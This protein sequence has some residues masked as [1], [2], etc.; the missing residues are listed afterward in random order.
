MTKDSYVSIFVKSMRV[1]LRVGL[2]DFEKDAP[3]PVDVEVELFT[4]PAYLRGATEESIIDYAKIYED[5]KNWEFRDHVELLEPYLADL[6][7]LA[8]SFEAVSAA[9]VSIAKPDIFAEAQGAGV[10]AYM[11]RSDWV[12]CFYPV[13]H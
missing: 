13:R 7:E 1:N 12:S 10:S 9:R 8:F 11:K 6:L 2:Q 5:V 3:Q 4:D